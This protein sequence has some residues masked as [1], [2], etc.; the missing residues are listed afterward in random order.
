MGVA[1]D[2][3]SPEERAPAA[4][5]IH[6]LVG[7]AG[8]LLAAAFERVRR[9]EEAVSLEATV[10]ALGVIG[11]ERAQAAVLAS[12][13]LEAGTLVGGRAAIFRLADGTVIAGAL[14]G[15]A[16]LELARDRRLPAIVPAASSAAL[17]NVLEAGATVALVGLSEGRVLATIGPVETLTARLPL[18]E[19]IAHAGRDRLALIAERDELQQ[20]A[21]ELGRDV[22]SLGGALR[23]KED[24]LATAVHELKNPLT[25]VHG[26]GAPMSRNLQPG[27]GQLAQL[28]RLMADLLS[29]EQRAPGAEGAVDAVTEAREAIARARVRGAT[30]DLDA[31]PEPVRLAIGQA[32]FAQL[33]DNLLANAL[34]YSALSEPIVVRVSAADD[35][36]KVSVTDRGIGIPAE[37][38]TRIFDRF[39]R[40]GGVADEVAGQG[41]GLTICKEIVAAHGGRIWAESEGPGRGSIFTFT[42]PLAL[43]TPAG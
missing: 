21:K 30:I 28:E 36:G 31:P 41:L 16:L 14:P 18:L 19:R 6:D 38:I 39:Y 25:A 37:H 12:C 13:L 3:A 22:E 9:E 11:A 7:D 24:A 29:A 32:R 5:A 33:L 43:R 40:V 1:L 20:A 4:G 15:S 10:R 27:R 26:H 42:L 2:A 17:A 35:E 23:A 34:K 8:S